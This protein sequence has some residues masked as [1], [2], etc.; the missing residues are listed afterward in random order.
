M[1]TLKAFRDKGR[2]YIVENNTINV[3]E[4]IEEGSLDLKNTLHVHLCR[5]KQKSYERVCDREDVIE[6]VNT[7]EEIERNES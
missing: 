3:Y 6:F 5:I 7:L 1:I 4:P 2:I